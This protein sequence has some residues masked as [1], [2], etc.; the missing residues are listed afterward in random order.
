MIRLL[1][2]LRAFSAKKLKDVATWAAGPGFH[3]SR[4]WRWEMSLHTGL[5]AV[6]FKARK[7]R[8]VRN[9]TALATALFCSAS[10]ALAETSFSCLPQSGQRQDRDGQS[11]LRIKGG[12]QGSSR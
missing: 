12:A 7:S 8:E 5:L 2:T 10:A 3:I 1:L 11:T 9:T 4:P 6:G